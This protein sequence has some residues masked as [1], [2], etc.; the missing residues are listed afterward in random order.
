[1]LSCPDVKN[2]FP[3]KFVYYFSV[4]MEV[5][6]PPGIA[7]WLWYALG[8]YFYLFFPHQDNQLRKTSFTKKFLFL[9]LVFTAHLV[10]K[11]L[12]I[13]S[14]LFLGFPFHFSLYTFL[15]QHLII[16]AEKTNLPTLFFVFS[17]VFEIYSLLFAFP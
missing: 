11:Q 3:Y 13:D 1:M 2:I 6:N 16:T 17:R 12:F 5:F 10:L 9:P 8:A 7:S 4:D 15:C 14:V